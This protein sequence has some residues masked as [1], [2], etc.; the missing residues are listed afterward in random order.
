ML[1]SVRSEPKFR[2][3]HL[4]T[5]WFLGKL[6]NSL[7]LFSQRHSGDN[8]TCLMYLNNLPFQQTRKAPDKGVIEV[9][10]TKFLCIPDAMI[11]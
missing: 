6:R 9:N 1:D 7:N 4:L 8:D 10:K 11:K 2:F 3:C 5:V